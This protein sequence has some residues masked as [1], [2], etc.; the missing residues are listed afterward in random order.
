[1]ARSLSLTSFVM[2]HRLPWAEG[3]SA[4]PA[5]AGRFD[6]AVIIDAGQR[7]ACSIRSVSSLGATL[8]GEIAKRQGDELAIEL[9]TGQRPAAT[10][11]WVGGGEAGVR[12][13]RPIDVVA[14]INRTLISQ[15]AE[16][17]SMPRVELRCGVRLK[18][19]ATVLDAILRNISARGLQLEADGLPPRGTYV[20]IYIDGL[21]VPAG[22]VMWRK[23][24]LA[25]IQLMEE[26]SWTSLMPWIR[27]T[28]GGKP[29]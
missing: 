4:A 16:R 11:E 15:P 27:K 6:Q 25:G 18:W 22:E 19:G 24:D 9:V 28:S 29:A 10:V 21:I 12:F 13:K 8:T 23:D 5:G 17:R 7:S 26:L 1:M 14:L 20:S 3:S 2:E